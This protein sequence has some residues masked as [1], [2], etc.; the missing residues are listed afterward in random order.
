MIL[1]RGR[2]GSGWEEGEREEG[3]EKR[4]GGGRRDR[5]GRRRE[6]LAKEK[7]EMRE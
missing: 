7:A 5:E 2:K 6:R 3:E 1:L 4:E